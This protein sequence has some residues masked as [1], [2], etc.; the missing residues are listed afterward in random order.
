MTNQVNLALQR[1]LLEDLR[2]KL[3]GDK[4]TLPFT[5]Y[6]DET[7]DL[8]LQKQPKSLEELTQIKGFP[9]EGKRVKGFGE[10]IVQ[11]FNDPETIENATVV[12]SGNELA[13]SVQLK[14][15]NCF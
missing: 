2:S 15:L 10:Y 14:N 3:I 1:R 13:V 9:K 7:I 11:I 12:N 4:H 8:L 6:T 5:I